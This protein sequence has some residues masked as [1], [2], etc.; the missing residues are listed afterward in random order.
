MVVGLHLITLVADVVDRYV[1]CARSIG[2]EECVWSARQGVLDNIS[3]DSWAVSEGGQS[4]DNASLSHL[5]L[6]V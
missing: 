2:K 1:V 3:G 5:Y 4:L 6:M